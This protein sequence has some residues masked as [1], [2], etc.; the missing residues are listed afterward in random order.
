MR[1]DY[2]EELPHFMDMMEKLLIS[3]NGGDEY[4]V[5]NEVGSAGLIINNGWSG[6]ILCGK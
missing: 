6:W 1:R 5:G 3:N 4:F 2:E